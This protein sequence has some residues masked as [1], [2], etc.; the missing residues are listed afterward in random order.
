VST[1]GSSGEPVLRDASLAAAAGERLALVGPSGAGKTS[2]LYALLHFVACSKGRAEIGVLDVSQLTR[3][4]IATMAGWVPDE[5]HV[6]SATL[7]DN[8][9]LAQPAASDAECLAA[10]SRAS[11]ANWTADLPEGL[12]TELG[13][14]GRPVSAGERQRLGLARALLAGSPLLL[15][16][17]PTARLDPATAERLVPELLASAGRRTVI[18]VSHDHSVKQHV[19]RVVA[20]RGGSTNSE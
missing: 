12:G 3:K 20:L 18:V 5:T 6:F 17:E 15:L 8:L 1:V 19:D 14:G 16:D 7:R 2:A 4:D 10:L 13:A 11:L 9:R